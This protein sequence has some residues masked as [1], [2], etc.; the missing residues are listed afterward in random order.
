MIASLAKIGGHDLKRVTWN[1]LGRLYTDDVSHQINW[2]GVNHKKAFS[3]MSAKSLLF[4]QCYYQQIKAG[5]MAISYGESEQLFGLRLSSD[6]CDIIVTIFG[7]DSP[8]FV[9]LDGVDSGCPQPPEPLEEDLESATMST[10]PPPP[11]EPAVA[12][13]SCPS[14]PISS[15]PPAKKRRRSEDLQQVLMEKEIIR[16]ELETIKLEAET[17]KM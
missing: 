14:C 13:P 12:T 8:A 17:K 16:V 11:I 15:P 2:K 4:I 5:D 3:Q 6:G 10:P 9:G 7:E 1:I